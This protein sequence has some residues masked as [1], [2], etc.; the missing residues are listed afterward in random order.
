MELPV[1]VA[2]IENSQ[3][4]GNSYGITGCWVI[5]MELPVILAIIKNSRM[6]GNSYG[7]TDYILTI[8][9]E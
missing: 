3:M 1:R 9:R 4:L 6:L 7:I 2:I 8:D 5:R